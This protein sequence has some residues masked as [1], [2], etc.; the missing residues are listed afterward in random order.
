GRGKA[1]YLRIGTRSGV[2]QCALRSAQIRASLRRLIVSVAGENGCTKSELENCPE[3]ILLVSMFCRVSA[4]PCMSR[5]L[6]LDCYMHQPNDSTTSRPRI[7]FY[8]RAVFHETL[9][10]QSKGHTPS[11]GFP[12][13]GKASAPASDCWGFEKPPTKQP[14]T[15]IIFP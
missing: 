13:L 10:I 3:Y 9:V 2:Y 14:A 5:L 12:R 8:G 6:P 11:H 1:Q 4:S 15:T 7:G